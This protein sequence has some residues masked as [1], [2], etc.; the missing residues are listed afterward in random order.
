MADVVENKIREGRYAHAL[1][2]LWFGRYK[3][4]DWAPCMY[5][6]HF[7]IAYHS[8]SVRRIRTC[9]AYEAPENRGVLWTPDKRGCGLFNATLPD[10]FIPLSLRGVLPTDWQR[11]DYASLCSGI[12][13]VSDNVYRYIT[14]N[15][16]EMRGVK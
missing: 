13:G 3:E 8:D 12:G 1:M 4:K 2:L 16:A 14:E 10:D 6:S 5:C 9:T 7:K 15:A 11:A